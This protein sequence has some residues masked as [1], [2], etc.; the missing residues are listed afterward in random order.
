MERKFGESNV[1]TEFV[2]GG[3]FD[4]VHLGH[5][6]VMES[7]RELCA[8]WSLRVLPCSVPPLK[9]LASAS[10]EQRVAMLKLVTD[11]IDNLQIDERENKR[12]GKSYTLDSLQS[13]AQQYPSKNFV[14]V[15][16]GDTLKSMNQWHEWQ[17]L[18][19]YCHLL[20]VNRPGTKIENIVTLMYQLGFNRVKKVQELE[21]TPNG[22]YYCL[23]MEAFDISS[24][25]IRTR[26]SNGLSVDKLIS[27]RV[28]D[29]IKK[30]F[31]YK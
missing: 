26:L 18:A 21:V 25:E 17:Q 8:S 29:Y 11:S 22:R 13:L 7:L 19:N 1:K 9:N 23:N 16:G 12:E 24:T 27:K 2:F 10:F 20:L 28:M 4:P 3:S 30:N 6:H 14:L 15:V 31:I 5:L